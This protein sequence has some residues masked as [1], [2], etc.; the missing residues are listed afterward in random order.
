[1]LKLLFILY[2]Q[3]KYTKADKI[4]YP[5]GNHSKSDIT[6]FCKIVNIDPK[7]TAYKIIETNQTTNSFKVKY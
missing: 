4:H 7:I 2:W 3:A 5:M 1:M 6:F